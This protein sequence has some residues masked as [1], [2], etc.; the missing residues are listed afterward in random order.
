MT[1]WHP[2]SEKP[3]KKDTAI[4]CARFTRADENYREPC[5][6]FGTHA[7]FIFGIHLDD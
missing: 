3:L 6:S 1:P 2:P 4:V 5:V 7:A